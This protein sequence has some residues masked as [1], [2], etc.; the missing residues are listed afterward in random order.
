MDMVFNTQ[1]WHL[2]CEITFDNKFV[3]TQNHIY[4]LPKFHHKTD[5]SSMIFSIATTLPL[6]LVQ[7][8]NGN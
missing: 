6:C 4:F 5:V 8:F 7:R 1:T 3:A 2:K